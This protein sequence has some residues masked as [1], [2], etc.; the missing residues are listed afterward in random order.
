MSEKITANDPTHS[1]FFQLRAEPMTERVEGDSITFVTGGGKV[2]RNALGYPDR[3]QF[4]EISDRYPQ[5]S[6][7]KL[8]D[9]DLAIAPKPVLFPA[10]GP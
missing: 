9:E 5:R 7:L 3:D 1:E 10:V 6:P 8:W 4:G 2:I